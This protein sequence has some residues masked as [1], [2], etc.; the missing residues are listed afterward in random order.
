MYISRGSLTSQ[1]SHCSQY[2]CASIHIPTTP[3]AA[4]VPSSH[5]RVVSPNS[6]RTNRK[7]TVNAAVVT[8]SHGQ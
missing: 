8:I 3:S 7:A 1:K 2:F 6:A 5:G 4:T